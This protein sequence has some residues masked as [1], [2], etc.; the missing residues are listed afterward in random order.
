MYRGL[1]IG[2]N[3]YKDSGIA[4]LSF[5]QQDAIELHSLFKARDYEAQYLIGDGATADGMV[6]AV[7]KA[8]SG[9]KSGD[10]FVFFFAGHGV[11]RGDKYLLLGNSALLDFLNDSDFGCF[12]V[13]ILEQISRGNGGFKRVFIFDTCR[14]N[15]C[16]GDVDGG[17]AFAGKARD[18]ALWNAAKAK[19]GTTL[20]LCS[21]KA[22]QRSYEIDKLGHG[23]F[24]LALINVIERVN[25]SG[26]LI[27]GNLPGRIGS[28]MKDLEAEYVMYSRQEMEVINGIGNMPAVLEEKNMESSGAPGKKGKENFEPH[29]PSPANKPEPVC[30]DLDKTRWTGVFSSSLAN[31]HIAIGVSL[32]MVLINSGTFTMGSLDLELGREK[33]ESLRAVTITRDFWIG[34]YPVTQ[35][36][37]EAVE[38]YNPSHFKS[39]SLNNT[40]FSKNNN[41]C[42]KVEQ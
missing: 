26:E 30:V 17:A 31:L 7:R 10:S 3:N 41:T 23:L 42:G 25:P 11:E 19:A 14:A 40:Y 20:F 27:F 35:A 18:A 16:A 12:P 28:A 37:Y 21:C 5:A 32:E 36:Q 4:P 1:F 13:K 2:I 33:N 6:D 38:G 24:T 34:K 22:G 29:L 15:F 8:V 39:L 9:L